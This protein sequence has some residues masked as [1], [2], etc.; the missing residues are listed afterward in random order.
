[1]HHKA[2]KRIENISD[3]KVWLKVVIYGY[4]VGAYVPT[5]TDAEFRKAFITKPSSYARESQQV[6]T[7]GRFGAFSKNGSFGASGR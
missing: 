5:I 3:M 7:P 2:A 4:M 6:F 1:M